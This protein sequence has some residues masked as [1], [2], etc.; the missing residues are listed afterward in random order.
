MDVYY[1]HKRNFEEKNKKINTLQESS[2]VLRKMT[3]IE[4]GETEDYF[5]HIILFPK[6]IL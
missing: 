5:M 1:I 4:V 6:R 2:I 3:R